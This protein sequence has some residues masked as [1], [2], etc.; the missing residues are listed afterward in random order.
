M[1]SD[2]VRKDNLDGKPH[3]ALVLPCHNEEKTVGLVI[4]EFRI[5][6]PNLSFHVFDNNSTDKTADV[7]RAHGAF[8]HK[9]AFQG[10]GNVVRRIFADV[11]ADIYVMV[12]GD[13]TYDASQLVAHV[14]EMIDC[15]IDMV[16]G[17]RVI[18]VSSNGVH[19][20]VGH[21]I[22]NKILTATAMMVFGG[23]FSDMLSGYRIFSRRYAKSFA[24]HSHGFETETEL[25]I[26]ALELRM[27]CLEV[28]VKY[29]T[30]PQGSQ[31]KLSTYRDGVRILRTIFRLI[32]TERP[33]FLFGLISIMLSILSIVIGLPVVYDY[34]RTGLVPRLPTA[35][36]S[37]GVMLSALLSFVCGILLDQVAIGRREVKHLCYLSYPGF[38]N[39]LVSRCARS[40]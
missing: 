18:D 34:V 3:I 2:E 37:M 35:V 17:A 27:P 5:V 25:T 40:D 36:L 29:R 22:G 28:P 23:G 38:D 9:V 6:C 15:Q 16:L 20:R 10:K 11:E 4:D 14:K 21:R 33:F 32:M 26:H 7:A 1:C 39:F 13:A 12:D 30:R 24:A 31:S 19:Y 8:V